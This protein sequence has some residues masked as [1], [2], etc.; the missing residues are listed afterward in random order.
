MA[1]AESEH[2]DKGVA[3][4]KPEVS[5]DEGDEDGA[6][7][8]RDAKSAD[9]P[10]AEGESSADADYQRSNNGAPQNSGIIQPPSHHGWPPP[11]P[12][13]HWQQHQQPAPWDWRSH[14]SP[15]SYSAP[16]PAIAAPD[17]QQHQQQQQTLASS[18]AVPPDDS[19]AAYYHHRYSYPPP[20]PPGMEG[21]YGG[22]AIPGGGGNSTAG[23]PP[24][25]YPAMHYAPGPPPFSASQPHPSQMSVN[26]ES[27]KMRVGHW[28][29]EEEAY[30]SKISEFFASG[31]L[32]NC[33]EGM[34]LR[35]LLVNLLNCAPMRVSK[36]FSG[37]KG[38]GKRAY[39]HAH[40]SLDKEMQE[41]LPLEEGFHRSLG[42]ASRLKL[43]L[44]G[45]SNL[46]TPLAAKQVLLSS[47]RRDEQSK[48]KAPQPY[49]AG[50]SRAP[51][52]PHMDFY[53]HHP[54]YYRSNFLPQHQPPYGYHPPPPHHHPMQQ[55]P[56]PP[57]PPPQQ[58]VP[59][60]SS[61]REGTNSVPPISSGSLSHPPPMSHAP[62][63]TIS[64]SPPL[65]SARQ[66]P[67]AEASSPQEDEALI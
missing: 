3:D 1:E 38:V 22:S 61:V 59:L 64:P 36:K 30:A 8:P 54:Y 52:V 67:G 55:Q 21:Y 19:A 31:R 12:H 42:D 2:P 62:G 9:A 35:S 20:P 33:P 10:A 13:P 63:S 66:Q 48:P 44:L 41:L 40:G 60:S 47:K 46:V 29:R 5:P 65:S 6:D 11:S 45:T 58:H 18:P 37:E 16:P 34:T 50:H 28:T 51:Q 24:S 32:P 43:S 23:G 39:K 25:G 4:V 17:D 53:A 49:Y 7:S 15:Y 27:A 57:P 26:P 56:L 14:Y